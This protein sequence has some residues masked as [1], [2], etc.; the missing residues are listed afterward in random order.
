MIM[1]DRET[2]TLWQKSTGKALAGEHYPHRL[3]LH[4]VQ[5][6]SVGDIKDRYPD[7]EI[8]FYVEM[9]FSW[10]VQNDDGQ[11]FDPQTD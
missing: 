4:S 3:E 1:F 6:L 8:L 2:E 5:L 7:A 9:W 11:V 10:A